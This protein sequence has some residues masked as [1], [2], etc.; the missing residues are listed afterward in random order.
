M[1]HWSGQYDVVSTVHGVHPLVIAGLLYVP[2]DWQRHCSDEFA[3]PV[4]VRSPLPQAVGVS[5]PE[6]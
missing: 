1:D 4:R 5:P 2:V 3:P 6:Q